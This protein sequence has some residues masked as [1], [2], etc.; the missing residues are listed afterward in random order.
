[1]PIATLALA[2]H[3]CHSDYVKRQSQRDLEKHWSEQLKKQTPA[4][5][6]AIKAE[7]LRKRIERDKAF[8]ERRQKDSEDSTPQPA[9]PTAASSNERKKP[10]NPKSAGSARSK[11]KE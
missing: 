9:A 8:L 6:L 5:R 3:L 10:G 4:E 11:A 7:K 1:M 2:L